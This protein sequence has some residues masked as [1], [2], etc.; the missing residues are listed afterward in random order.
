MGEQPTDIASQMRAGT[1]MNDMLSRLQRAAEQ[2]R[3]FSADAAHELRTPL[4]TLRTRAEVALAHPEQTDWVATT[5]LVLTQAESMTRLVNDLLLLARADSRQL[6]AHRSDVDLD[7]LLLTEAARLREQHT[8]DISLA[9]LKPVCVR[10][11]RAQLA[12]AL[13]NLGDNAARHARARIQLALTHT[14][15]HAIITIAD[16]G[17][18]ILPDQTEAIFDRFTPWMTPATT[19]TAEPDWA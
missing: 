19:T 9:A 15:E 1:T 16:D 6:L 17:P 14:A 8:H 7:D 3:R 10:G 2:Q 18:G 4:T 12:R 11:D 13:S 5:G